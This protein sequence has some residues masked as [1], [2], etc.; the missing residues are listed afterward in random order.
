[1]V[2][3]NVIIKHSILTTHSILTLFLPL[4]CRFEKKYFIHCNSIILAILL[5]KLNAIQK[6]NLLNFFQ[7][8][9]NPPPMFNAHNNAIDLDILKT[10]CTFLHLK[11]IH[12]LTCPSYTYIKDKCIKWVFVDQGTINRGREGN[13]AVAEGAKNL[14]FY[15][16]SL[17]RKAWPYQVNQVLFTLIV[18]F[19]NC[20]L[21]TVIR[22]EKYF[23]FSS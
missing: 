1:M 2:Y 7:F 20:I 15:G 5:L 9:Y 18:D 11:F 12:F 4:L 16:F 21:R 8:Q 6:P 10:L 14:E 3:G 17:N 22:V 23:S 13:W 19:R